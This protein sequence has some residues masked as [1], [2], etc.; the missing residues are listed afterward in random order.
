MSITD[1]VCTICLII[2]VSN[3]Y[4]S[5]VELNGL[6]MEDELPVRVAL[7]SDLGVH[8]G[9]TWECNNSGLADY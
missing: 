2:R 6:K 1:L 8:C 3:R 5:Q 7:W 9:V 4:A